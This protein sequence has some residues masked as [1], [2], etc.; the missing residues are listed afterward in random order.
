MKKVTILGMKGA[1]IKQHVITMATSIG[2]IEKQI[3]LMERIKSVLVAC[4]EQEEYDNQ[5]TELMTKMLDNC[6]M[7]SKELMDGNVVG[8]RDVE[9]VLIK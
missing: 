6:K 4:W 1:A 9:K 5:V 8:D 7:S 3:Y 2:M